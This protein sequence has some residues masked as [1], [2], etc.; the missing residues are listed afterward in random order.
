MFPS[1]KPQNHLLATAVSTH[2][3][4]LLKERA[5]AGRGKGGYIHTCAYVHV[6]ESSVCVCVIARKRACEK[7]QTSLTSTRKSKFR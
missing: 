3:L 2:E 1:V 6:T 7:K 4:H 5:T